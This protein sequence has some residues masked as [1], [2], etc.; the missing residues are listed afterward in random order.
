MAYARL[1]RE[2]I[3]GH[4]L[5]PLL[6]SVGD[7]RHVGGCDSSETWKLGEG[8]WRWVEGPERGA[9][10]VDCGQLAKCYTTLVWH[11]GTA[12]TS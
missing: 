1:G 4:Q 11:C 5:W 10:C 12:S 6:P 9:A 2:T 7:K 8:A 3:F